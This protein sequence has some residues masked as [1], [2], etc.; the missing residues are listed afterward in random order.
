MKRFFVL[1]FLLLGLNEYAQENVNFEVIDS[2]YREDQFYFGVT[3]NI[4]N[5]KPVGM[6][7]NSFSAGLS[8][9]ILRDFPINKS[10]TLAIAPGVGLSYSNYKQ[11]L[12]ISNEGG[13]TQYNLIAPSNEYDKNKFSFASIDI[14]LELRWRTSTPNSHKFWRVYSG[15]KF[16]YVL[17]NRS[18]YKD[19][20]ND[21]K[22]VNN[23]D[24][25]KLHYGVYLSTGYNTWNIYAYYGLNEFFKK[26]ILSDSNKKLSS[27]N[28]GLMFYIL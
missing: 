17:Y 4:L 14:P 13:I 3:Y 20:K 19:F 7:Q 11:N 24:F 9:G 6:S 26:Q 10:R 5:N 23:D 27:L 16:S 21:F 15:V 8:L 22:V 18:R 25:N 28:I 2:L 12:I 1:I